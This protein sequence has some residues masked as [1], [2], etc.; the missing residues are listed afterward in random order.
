LKVERAIEAWLHQFLSSVL[1]GSEWSHLHP[2]RST[3]AERTTRSSYLLLRDRKYQCFSPNAFLGK[4][5][6]VKQP[7]ICFFKEKLSTNPSGFV[8][9]N[10][11]LHYWS[12]RRAVNPLPNMRA[13]GPPAF[14]CPTPLVYSAYRQLLHYGRL[15][16]PQPEDAL[17]RGDRTSTARVYVFV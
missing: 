11:L 9:C 12:Q 8:Y 10:C 1:Y 3:P 5:S 14:G 13:A 17:C 6:H 4:L 16:H 2:G 7:S 15:L